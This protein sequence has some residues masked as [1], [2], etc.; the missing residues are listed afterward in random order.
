MT[1]STPG[2][3]PTPNMIW[4]SWN[5]NSGDTGGIVKD[6]WKEINWNKVAW[7]QKAAGLQPWA[8]GV[9]G[10]LP[11]AT[12]PSSVMVNGVPSAYG[13]NSMFDQSGGAKP[14]APAAPAAAPASSSCVD[15]TTTD[16]FSCEQQKS[17]G[18][19][20]ADWFVAAGF[21][22][23][24]CGRCPPAPKAVEEIAP[25][26]PAAAAAGGAAAAAA[27]PAVVPPAAAAA[28]AAVPGVVPATATAVVPP[29]PKPVAVP[30][31]SAAV[32]G[33][34]EP[35]AAG[36]VAPAPASSAFPLSSSATKAAAGIV[37][38]IAPAPAS[39]AFP[40][41]SSATKAAAAS[42]RAMLKETG[43][44]ALKPDGA[45]ATLA[46]SAEIAR[47]LEAANPTSPVSQ[48]AAI[49][50]AAS[51]LEGQSQGHVSAVMA[52]LRAAA[53]IDTVME[54]AAATATAVDE[55]ALFGA[56]KAA[57][58]EALLE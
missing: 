31:S 39:S 9:A 12:G 49:T 16:G 15:K 51:V 34:P 6:D 46:D 23:K 4:W 17:W 41:S 18:K 56:A 42:T 40:P 47:M 13:T 30:A 48:E 52:Q 24:T 19:C 33:A 28:A 45:D 55:A 11:G 14:V 43:A 57:A 32:E 35:L 50:A 37:A 21:C 2:H 54:A 20:S 10:K 25:P 38:P 26:E 58:A 27:V 3:N 44:L 8:L 36:I 53:A 22:Q 7:L 1:S 29:P 5:A